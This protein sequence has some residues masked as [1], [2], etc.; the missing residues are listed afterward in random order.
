MKQ[1]L[2]EIED[3]ARQNHNDIM[4]LTEKIEKQRNELIAL[5]EK[6]AEQAVTKEVGNKLDAIQKDVQ[7]VRVKAIKETR[8]EIR[9]SKA[10]LKNGIDESLKR[11][12]KAIDKLTGMV[13]KNLRKIIKK[14]DQK[15]DLQ[16]SFLTRYIYELN[17]ALKKKGILEKSLDISGELAKLPQ[18]KD[19]I[20]IKPILASKVERGKP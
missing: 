9:L 11:N 2:N 17:K 6:K 16:A 15:T 10:A 20:C 3:K 4:E 8:E 12:I 19:K 5:I 14:V 13:E 18:Y 7:E 1:Q